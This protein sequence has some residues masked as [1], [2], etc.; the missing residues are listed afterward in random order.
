LSDFTA[1]N[2]GYSR[3]LLPQIK[4]HSEIS[5]NPFQIKPLSGEKNKEHKKLREKKTEQKER[6]IRLGLG[7]KQAGS[8]KPVA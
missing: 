1:E 8:T 4:T 6:N 5:L 3:C 7:S 2:P